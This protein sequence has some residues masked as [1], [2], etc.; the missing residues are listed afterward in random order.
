[1]AI[2]FM[3]VE[4]TIKL[5]MSNEEAYYL[6][7]MLQNPPHG[8]SPSEEPEDESKHRIDLF[9]ALDNILP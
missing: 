2:A 8:V 9:K 1:M 5:E 3:K 6:R 7:A 4:R